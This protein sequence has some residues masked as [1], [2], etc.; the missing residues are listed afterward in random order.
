M[1]WPQVLIRY[2]NEAVVSVLRSGRTRDPYLRAC[3]MIIWYVSA[4]ADIDLHYVHIRGLDN[5]VADLLSRWTVS[6]KDFSK[7]LSQVLDSVWVPVDIRLL[8]IDPEL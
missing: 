3:A 1:V 4:L 5:W 8:D 7:L 6:S 2:D